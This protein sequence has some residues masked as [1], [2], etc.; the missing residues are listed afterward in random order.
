MSTKNSVFLF[1]MM[2]VAA[3]LVAQQNNDT[4]LS[5]SDAAQITRSRKVKE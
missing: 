5:L 3:P 2:I 4:I 1:L